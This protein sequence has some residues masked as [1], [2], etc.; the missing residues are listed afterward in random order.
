MESDSIPYGSN[1]MVAVV[2]NNAT[3]ATLDYESTKEEFKTTV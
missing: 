3:H 2:R 1:H